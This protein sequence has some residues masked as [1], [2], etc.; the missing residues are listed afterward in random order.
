MKP[1]EKISLWNIFKKLDRWRLF[2][3]KLV[4]S[5]RSEQYFVIFPQRNRI[6]EGFCHKEIVEN[7][8]D[9]YVNAIYPFFFNFS[10]LSNIFG[11]SYCFVSK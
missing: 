9:E 6:L 7:R 4:K 1:G 3:V 5:E 2:F 8:K 10:I 11:F